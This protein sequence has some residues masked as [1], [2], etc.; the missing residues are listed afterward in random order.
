MSKYK[1]LVTMLATIALCT[2][3]TAQRPVKGPGMI[4]T[5]SN[6]IKGKKLDVLRAR[7]ANGVPFPVPGSVSPD[8]HP[9]TGGKTMGAA[10]DGR[11]LPEWEEF[12][13]KVWPYPYPPMPSD[14]VALQTWS[15]GV[16]AMSR[17]LPIQTA[18]VAVKSRV[19]QEV[20]DEVLLSNK[21]RAP[22]ALPDKLLWVYFIW[23]ESGIKF[24]W[25]LE[26]GCCKVLRAGGDDVGP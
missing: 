26:Q 20:L 2:A 18:R 23:Y 25:S 22:R 24:R 15:E 3:C 21:N 11:E 9:M 8:K 13:W 5:F 6:G 4:A 10:P 12:E 17:S 1:L 19:P 16:H 14:P 7:T